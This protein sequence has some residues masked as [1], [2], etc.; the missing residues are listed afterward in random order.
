MRNWK[1]C[2]RG[3]ER[4][5]MVKRLEGA[6]RERN[7]HEDEWKTKQEREVDR[8]RVTGRKKERGTYSSSDGSSGMWGK[9]NNTPRTTLQANI[10]L[11]LST[12]WGAMV[13]I[14]SMD[15]RNNESKEQRRGQ[16]KKE[17]KGREEGNTSSCNPT[18]IM[19]KEKVVN[20]QLHQLW[21]TDEG[22][23]LE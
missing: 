10:M 11:E 20:N 15:Q 23:G 14:I 1:E 12:R 17:R 16:I 5:G 3:T 4:R 18:K 8:E 9:W 7:Q 13:R 6:S 21:T 19:L 22:K 2:E